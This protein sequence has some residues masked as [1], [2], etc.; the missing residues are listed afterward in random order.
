MK[1]TLLIDGDVLVYQIGCT[2]ETPIHW[3]D[4]MWS[5]HADA[6][7]ANQRLDSEIADWKMLLRADDV[8]VALSCK[9]EDGFRRRICP[10][11]KA[12][13]KNTRKPVVHQSMREHMMQ[14]YG[15]IL[16]PDLE[17]DDILGILA[18]EEH[19]GERIICS[20]DKDFRGVPCNY[21]N[22]RKEFEGV[23][24]VTE[25]DAARFHAM[26]TL[27]GDATDGY[28]GIPG[29]GP[30]K[31]EKILAEAGE[32]YWSTIVAAYQ[33]A[34]LSEEV[35][36]TNARLARILRSGDY[37][38]STGKINLWTPRLLK[39]PTKTRTKKSKSS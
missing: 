23:T 1:T 11:Y 3:G 25:E 26:Q 9:T 38:R 35:A 39:S 27:H 37:D 13:R 4:D 10:T 14:A 20:V 34:G 6:K 30:V 24:T 17:A 22:F 19:V 28:Q 21:Y 32:D 29:V 36:L 5:L 12:N 7:E 31:A 15:A 33:K 2:V 18:T 16:R 8:I